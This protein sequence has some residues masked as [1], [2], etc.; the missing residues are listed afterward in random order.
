[1]SAVEFFPLLGVAPL[2]GRTISD[3][4]RPNGSSVAVLS[5]RA[6]QE[7]LRGD[8]RPWSAQTCSDLNQVRMERV[9]TLL[10]DELVTTTPRR[11]SAL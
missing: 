11:Q 2:F 1:M 9:T 5:Y 7:Q 6:W 3:D 10:L 8:P 4:D